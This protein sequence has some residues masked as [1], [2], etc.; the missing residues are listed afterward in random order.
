MSDEIKVTITLP[1]GADDIDAQNALY[2]ATRHHVSGDIHND[3]PF[4]DA[5]MA[6]LQDLLTKTHED[7]YKVMLAEIIKV[8]DEDYN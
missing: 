4:D 2:K 8:L 6:N 3:Q 5:A 7:L 1:K